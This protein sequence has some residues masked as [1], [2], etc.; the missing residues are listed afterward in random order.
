MIRIGV[1]A[2]CLL[3]VPA[4]AHPERLFELVDE[5][6]ELMQTVAAWKWQ[7]HVPIEDLEREAVVLDQATSAALG[8]GLDPATTREFFSIQIDAA[9]QIQSRWFDNFLIQRPRGQAPDLSDTRKTLIE[10]GDEITREI[11]RV[12]PVGDRW[13]AEFDRAVEVEGLTDDTKK[14]L[15]EALTE[16]RSFDSR[17]DQILATGTIRVGT[18]GDYAPFS[19]AEDGDEPTGIDIDLARDLAA[20]LGVEV[21]FIET[22]WPTLVEDLVAGKYDIAMSGVSRTLERARIGFFSP[23][24]HVGGKTPITR[25]ADRGKYN[26]LA[27]IDASDVRVIVNP[28]GTN[29]RF[30]ESNIREAEL[31]VFGDNRK[32][33]D[34]IAAG[35]ADV[36]ITDTI[37][38]RLISSR[39]D[40]L[41]AAMPGETFTYQEKAY[42]MPMDS[43]LK[44]FVETWLETRLADGTVDKAFER[45]LNP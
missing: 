33:F 30:V 13:R 8:Q 19:F 27:A 23:P 16:I 39:M 14:A 43:A 34:E 17:L 11:R 4:Q 40:D 22:S 26:S 32:I 31:T 6:L 20:G 18:T 44:A 38:V 36:M 12:A 15:F 35:R 45:H 41:C 5:R 29:Y 28:G 24:Y 42:L 7:H 9:K 37:E 3:S 10:L 2:L 1:L 25:C 21:E